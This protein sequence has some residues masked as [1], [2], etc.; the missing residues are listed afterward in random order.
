M[1]NLHIA[2]QEGFENDLAVVSLD[3]KEVFRKAGLT[4]RL[5]IGRAHAFDLDVEARPFEVEI[6]L[7]EKGLSKTIRIDPARPVY[8]GISLADRGELALEVSHQPFGYL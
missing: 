4:T 3:G 2:F 1:P 8:L 6:T 7:P 5:Q